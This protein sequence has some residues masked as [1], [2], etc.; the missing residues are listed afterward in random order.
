MTFFGEY[1]GDVESSH[2]H[3]GHANHSDDGPRA[4]APA[5]HNHEHGH[6]GI[7]ESPKVMLI[8]LVIL[9]GAFNLWRMD[10]S[11]GLAWREQS[12]R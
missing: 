5:P 8:P 6:G 10:R 7:H 3:D 11:S 9:G 12:I 1:R 4:G 2:A